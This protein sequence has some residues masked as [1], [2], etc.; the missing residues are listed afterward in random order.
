MAR[1]DKRSATFTGEVRSTAAERSAARQQ[2]AQLA[3]QQQ[4][5]EKRNRTLLI[6]LAGLVVAA[7]IVGG[8]VFA[9]S[10]SSEPGLA[11]PA[12]TADGSF[13]V[14]NPDAPVTVQVV[15][16]FQCPACQAFEA[17]AG[18]VL[19]EYAA[20]DEVNIEYRGIA[21]LD[22]ASTTNYSTRAL[23]ASACVMGEGEEVWKEFHRQMYLQ[24]PAEGTAGLPDSDLVR[25][26]TEAGADEAAVS[27]CVEDSTYDDW[28]GST[29]EQSADDGVDSTPTVFVDGEVVE[30]TSVESLTSAVD[31]ALGS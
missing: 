30:V 4:A 12:A 14:G 6:T 18:D 27:S 10:R 17:A 5:R 20:G 25:I 24:Q 22:R 8:T 1:N 13:V 15:E 28:A 7:L 26:A 3:K 11:P 2:A 16:D 19:D 31:A 9:L 23:N 21:F 29:T